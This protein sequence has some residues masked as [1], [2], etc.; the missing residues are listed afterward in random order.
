MG[1]YDNGLGVTLIATWL[2]TLLAGIGLT[3]T[4]LYFAKFPN[5]IF[6]KALAGGVLFILLLGLATECAETYLDVV[7]YWGN[8]A[9]LYVVPWPRL[10]SI[11]CIT[12]MGFIVDQFLI[13]RFYTVSKNIWITIILS[14]CN[15]VSFAMGFVVLQFFASNIGQTLTPVD[16]RKLIP[17][18]DVWA[19]SSA[20]TDVAIV[21]SLVWALRGMKSSFENTT[22]L[23]QHIMV[24]SIQNG[25][26][27]SAVAI[28]GL[29]ANNLAPETSISYVFYY[30][31]G[32]L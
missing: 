21:A 3:H 24:V 32:L 26:T 2:S 27:T 16:L 8:P 20:V 10:V 4:V 30:T 1:A 13:H 15:L 9:A 14:M 19:A 28:G 18:S 5:E 7:T 22:Q 17:M 29:V 6:K 11:P 12:L 31:L 25:C 23:V